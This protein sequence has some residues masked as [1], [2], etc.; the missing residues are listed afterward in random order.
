M[1]QVHMRIKD[2][3]WQKVS[4]FTIEN[5]LIRLVENGVALG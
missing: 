2:P 3:I 5:L 4:Q 1:H